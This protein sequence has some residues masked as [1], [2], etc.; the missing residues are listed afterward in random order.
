MSSVPPP[1]GSFDQGITWHYGEP[2]REQRHIVT[3]NAAVD[4]G[5]RG[6]ITVTGPDRLTW[7]HSLTSQHLLDVQPGGSSLALILSPNGHV[8]YELHLVDDGETTWVITGP[9]V[10]PALLDYLDRMRFMLRVDVVDRSDDFAV[11]A[12]PAS[13]TEDLGWVAPEPF[14]TRGYAIRESI[15]PRSHAASRCAAYPQRAGSWALEA[16][17]VGA[18]MPRLGLDT[19]HRTIP[20]EMGWL[21]NAVHLNKGCYRGQETVAKVN[22]LGQ[23]PR[24]FVL[25]H[26]D[27]SVDELPPHGTAVLLDG[28]DIGWIGS[29]AQH[30]ELG[31][32]ATAV[33]KRSVPLNAPLGLAGSDIQASVELAAWQ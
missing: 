25:L 23:P 4:L 6:V 16:L 15:V 10:A 28:K 14:A 31:P 2:L 20:N 7:L 29:T 3:G 33:I 1:E 26:L 12:E 18:L 13:S 22:N 11:V 27:G 24:R 21:G 19:D 5:N 17:R 8:E 32:I 30:Y 9:G